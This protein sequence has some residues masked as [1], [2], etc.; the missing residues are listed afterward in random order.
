MR[1]TSGG[2]LNS[3]LKMQIRIF[4]ASVNTKSM[5]SKRNWRSRYWNY[6]RRECRSRRKRGSW[7]NVRKLRERSGKAK[8]LRKMKSCRNFW[9]LRRLWSTISLASRSKEWS[10]SCKRRFKISLTRKLTI[11]PSKP[12]SSTSKQPKRRLPTTK[13]LDLGRHLPMSTILSVRGGRELS[14][15]SKPQS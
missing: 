10:G 9:P 7:E 4:G 5:S 8:Q 2:R 15:K 6:E 11:F 12:S 3:T 14:P 13:K 1:P